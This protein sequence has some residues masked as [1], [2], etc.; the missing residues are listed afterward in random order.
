MSW[1]IPLNLFSILRT[2]NLDVVVASG[3]ANLAAV[4]AMAW[5]R[6]HG[7]GVVFGRKAL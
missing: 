7:R 6:A 4:G 3:Y 1:H 5:A 2:L